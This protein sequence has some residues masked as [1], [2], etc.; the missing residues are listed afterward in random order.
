[1]KDESKTR[2]SENC[3]SQKKKLH[4]VGFACTQVCVGWGDNKK[5]PSAKCQNILRMSFLIF[6]DVNSFVLLYF[7]FV[8]YDFGRWTQP[9]AETTPVLTVLNSLTSTKVPF[10]PR[11]GN[12]GVDMLF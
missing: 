5:N 9:V 10:V 11:V 7:L 1:M 12:E 8:L 4:K 2:E 3:H 6:M